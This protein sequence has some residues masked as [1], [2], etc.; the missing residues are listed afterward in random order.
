MAMA[1]NF[2]K[3]IVERIVLEVRFSRGF[4]YWDNCGK[5]WKAICE[6]WTDLEMVTVN[7]EKAEFK[8]KGEDLDLRF[9]QKGIRLSQYYPPSNLKLFKEVAKEAIPLIAKFLDIKSFSRV[10]NRIF[11][12]R[13][14]AD[15]KESS[16][17]ITSS[18]LLNISEDKI[19]LFGDSLE[20]PGIQFVVQD[21]D[22]AY[23]LNMRAIS[24]KLTLEVPKPIKVDGTKFVENAVLIDIDYFTKK[25]VDLA[26]TDFGYLIDQV[27]KSLKQNLS[28]LVS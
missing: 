4:L 15:M 24:R 11:Y 16:D 2:D 13:P 3:L 26:T 9:S 23:R 7:P 10:G 27:Q 6:K 1:I 8:M 12:L 21:E 5:I 20:E 22:V 18:E 25:S 14:T 19:K 17:I 28:K